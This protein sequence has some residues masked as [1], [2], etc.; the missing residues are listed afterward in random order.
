MSERK[1]FGR[2][3][4]RL[5]SFPETAR[6]IFDPLVRLHNRQAAEFT[7]KMFDAV[8]RERAKKPVRVVRPDQ[9][10]E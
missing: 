5:E 9:E 3:D 10:E 1:H 4:D 6:S 7:C 8:V 2:S